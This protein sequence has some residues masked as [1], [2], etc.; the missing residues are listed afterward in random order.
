[1]YL[2]DECAV[3]TPIAVA[4]YGLLMLWGKLLV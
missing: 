2:L 1:M 4:V 3:V